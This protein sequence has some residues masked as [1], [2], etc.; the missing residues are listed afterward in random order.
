VRCAD[1]RGQG[2]RRLALTP[3][4]VATSLVYTAHSYDG[5]EQKCE[6]ANLEIGTK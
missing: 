2:G 6:I 3:V 5:G 1:A 4:V